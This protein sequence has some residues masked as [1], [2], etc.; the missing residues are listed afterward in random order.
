MTRKKDIDDAVRRRQDFL[1]A[2]EENLS[3]N[4]IKELIV[5]QADDIIN[6][7]VK[8]NKGNEKKTKKDITVI[9]I[10]EGNQII[11]VERIFTVD[12]RNN[13]EENFELFSELFQ[14]LSSTDEVYQ[15]VWISFSE[16][17]NPIVIG[18]TS[19][20]EKEKNKKKF[21]D[22]HQKFDLLDNKTT[23]MLVNIMSRTKNT[24]MQLKPSNYYKIYNDESVEVTI[25]EII[26]QVNE[27]LN[28]FVSKAI[29]IPLDVSMIDYKQSIMVAS[30]IETLI[31]EY[32]VNLKNHEGN[33]QLEVLNN[34]S[35][36][37]Y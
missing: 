13:Q 24:K 25:L 21:G 12:L 10:L 37:Y 11:S 5:C 29:V 36:L 6:E 34:K 16:D 31:G 35:H 14:N 18:R 22:I 27:E 33:R 3:I 19:F 2:F 15:Y 20:D 30:K 1:N 26:E 32:L 7:Y 9:E 8:E 23:D 17:D 28:Q 4:A